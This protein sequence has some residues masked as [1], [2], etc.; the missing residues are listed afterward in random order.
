MKTL[1]RKELR[2]NLKLAVLS[3]IVF[4]VL[5][6]WSWCDYT[7]MIKD[8]LL[9]LRSLEGYRLQPVESGLILAGTAWLCVIFGAVLGW[10]QIFNE[11][12]RDLWAF[13]IHHP[14]SRTQI[15]FSKVIAG[16][17]IYIVAA[18]L[19]LVCFIVWAGI[20]GH[21]AAPFQWAMTLRIA[22]LF[23]AGI[24]FYFA[25]M[26]TGLRQARWYASRT[27]GLGLAFV[28]L[29]ANV[30]P[31]WQFWQILVAMLV[32]IT[33]LAT[34]V[35]GGFHSNGHYNG[36]PALGK[37][38]LTAS[39][40]VGAGVVVFIVLA[41]LA[42][43]LSNLVFNNDRWATY[44]MTK[45]GTIYKETQGGRRPSEFVDLNGKPLTDAKTGRMIES[46]EFNR[47]ACNTISIQM[48]WEKASLTRRNP[49]TFFT[50]WQATPDTI[51]YYWN[52]YGRLVGYDIAS[53]QCIGSI[54]P[55]GFAKDLAGGGDRFNAPDSRTLQT[56][57]A[58]YR[59]DL[60]N[61]ATKILFTTEKDETVLG[62]TDVLLN[63]NDWNYT[64]VATKHYIRLLTPEGKVV[65]KT[66]YEQAYPDSVRVR[67]SFLEKPGQ[68]ALW[69]APSYGANK[70]AG[71][72]LPTH[73]A[74]IDSEQ[75][76]FKGVDLPNLNPPGNVYPLRAKLLSLLMPPALWA[77]I[78]LNDQ[79][80]P[81][82]LPWKLVLISLAA[83]AVVWVPAGW[84][85][86]RRY[87]FNLQ[88]QLGWAAFHLLCGIP[89][90]LAF[91]SVQEWP[92]REPCSNCGKLRLVDREKCEHCGAA[93]APP[94]KNGTEIFAP[95]E[96]TRT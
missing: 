51:W 25:G 37:L 1:I 93:F 79:P 23:L 18:G 72:K 48:D 56:A 81:V 78:Y 43:L 32:G 57:T 19:P 33:I 74:W 4:T 70:R 11:R 58:I 96:A 21:V 71:W 8:V 31:T 52:R 54:G 89:G 5:V 34:A 3:L 59:A 77:G 55:N 44:V 63:G 88:T 16:L 46:E 86:G 28:I 2:E 10:M 65:W 20:P 30:V 67:V 24:A 9:G 91:L 27:F 87:S 36:Q 50:F 60:Q 94:E 83:A 62:A 64:V 90:F 13:L 14:V 84:W 66:P 95:L 76:I 47:R 41:L 17:G 85:L 49:A 6:V 69:V 68:Y 7:G 92:A 29:L 80:E 61:R 26:L 12:H 73:V 53:R 45:D 82:E 38:G 40:T 75:G 42:S 15:F 22:W 39:I 35:W